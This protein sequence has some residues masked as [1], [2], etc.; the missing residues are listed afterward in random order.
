MIRVIFCLLFV[1]LI[2]L[3][4]KAQ[5]GNALVLTGTTDYME[6][7]DSDLL[8]IGVGE[9]RTIT[10][11]VK[12]SSS[13]STYPRI[14][15]KRVNSGVGYEFIGHHTNG[16]FGINLET[17]S[18]QGVGP[19]WG[20]SQIL[21]G[22]WHH[23]AAVVDVETHTSYIY[24]DGNLEQT[25]THEKIGAEAIANNTNLRVGLGNSGG[26]PFVGMVDD[27]RFWNGAM[28]IDE[29]KADMTLTIDGN[30]DNLKVAWDFEQ[31]DGTVVPTMNGNL[32]GS[33]QNGAMVFNPQTDMVVKEVKI[34]QN[35]NNPIGRGTR[36]VS[37][38]SIEI[39]T[40]G[41]NNPLSLKQINLNLD[42]TTNMDNVEAIHV[43][44]ANDEVFDSAELFAE[45]TNVSVEMDLVGDMELL[46]GV[47]QFYVTFDVKED[48]S[49]IDNYLDF[50]CTSVLI[51]EED[52]EVAEVNPFGSHA[53]IEE[54]KPIFI[55]GTDETHTFR[56]PALVT[57]PNGDLICAI[58]ARRRNSADLKWARDIDIA[59][60]RSSDNG[61][62]WSDMEICMNLPDGEPVS[63]PSMIVDNVTD[64]I[65]LFYNYMHR[66][67]ADGK[68]YFLMQKSVDNGKSWSPFKD[69]TSQVTNPEWGNDFKFITSGRGTQTRDGKLL[70][71]MVNLNK[72]LHVFGSDDHGKSWYFIDQPVKP[73][74]ESKIVELANGTWMINSRVQG[75][76][77]RYVHTSKDAGRTWTSKPDEALIDPACNASIIRYTSIEDGYKKNRLLFSNAKSVR[78]RKNMTV[79]VSYDE[80]KTW[81]EGKT[82]FSGGAAYSDLTVMDDGTIGLVYEQSLPSRGYAKIQFARFSLEWLIDGAD[83]LEKSHVGT[84][85]LIHQKEAV[86][87]PNPSNG[88]FNVALSNLINAQTVKIIDISGRIIYSRELSGEEDIQIDLTNKPS[89]IYLVK[90]TAPLG[91]GIYKVIKN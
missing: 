55:S 3:N 41:M 11:W 51:G 1:G 61:K 77:K 81:T 34:V 47:N 67:T 25:K 9:S 44:R 88:I 36:N 18:G 5:S 16:T 14:L 22:E 69:I 71:C 86:I 49:T 29:I 64:E 90:I 35:D 50:G 20:T 73:A 46:S 32:D 66:D 39:S 31:T 27:L 65:F 4:V 12:S 72:G 38:G 45:V 63:D 57:A 6:V 91:G 19:S 40:M 76:G 60:K 84:P 58:D 78:G 42:G 33:L 79:R 62:T 82:I 54:H 85:E 89:G 15:A 48:A 28:T 37:I 17:S 24:V 13:S 80:G 87:Y 75:E 68:Y 43:Y 10:L 56:I 59:V 52:Y 8:D 53:L 74:N 70:H 30:E 2:H 83:H 7:S 21:D 26:N 23:L